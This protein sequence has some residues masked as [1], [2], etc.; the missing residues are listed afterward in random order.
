MSIPN[1]IKGILLSLHND[2]AVE[3]ITFKSLFNI[4]KYVIS[5]Y[6]TASG[7]NFGSAEY[8][9]SVVF[10]SNITSESVS[11]ALNAA[12]VSVEK[13]GLPVPHAKITTLPFSKCFV[14]F[15]FIYGSAISLISIAVCNLVYIPSCF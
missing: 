8:T 10:A 11:A 15:L 14:A 9:P 5:L 4:S 2:V 13:Y 3:S 12:A 6:S 1:T 7:S